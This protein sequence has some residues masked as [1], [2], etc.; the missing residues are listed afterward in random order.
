MK[1]HSFLP[2]LLPALAAFALAADP[3]VTNVRGQQRGDG[4][5]LVDVFY[6]LADPDSPTVT[7][8]L[9]VSADE[10]GTWSVP[11]TRASQAV[12]QGVQPGK[13]KYILWDAGADWN[14]QFSARTRFRV[15]A[16]DL[17]LA[18]PVLVSP[19]NNSTK[20]YNAP[21]H[22]RHVFIWEAVPGADSY[23]LV[24][25]DRLG[26]VV[27]DRMVEGMTFTPDMDLYKVTWQ[28]FAGKDGV[29]GPSSPIWTAK[30]IVFGGI[31]EI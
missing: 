15:T 7:V 10:G 11:V 19:A 30:V 23:R 26:T 5:K 25:R 24:V 18:A 8:R 12:G 6:D 14:N 2:C 28:V 9:E 27:V 16:S 29:F 21:A 22:P 1:L 3:V 17:T 31:G 20:Y 4:S 13:G